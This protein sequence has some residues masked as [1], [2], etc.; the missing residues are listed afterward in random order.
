[1]TASIDRP[2]TSRGRKYY[3]SGRLLVG[4]LVLVV[5]AFLWPASGA[6]QESLSKEQIQRFQHRVS[7]G[8]RLYDLDKFRAA[9]EQFEAAR[10][11]FDHPRLTF[12]I[13]Q[14]YRAL[15]ECT[16]AR[17]AYERY[18]GI[19]EAKAEV[20]ERARG[21]LGEL[22]D[23][24]VETGRLEVTCSPQDAT[25]TLIELDGDSQRSGQCPV[26]TSVRV[27]R[28]LVVAE[29]DGY[30]TQ[31]REVTVELN[32]KHAVDL[33]LSRRD[34]TVFAGM[35]AHS[36]IAY[37]AIGL[38][39]ASLMG[40]FVSDYTAVGRLDELSQAQA[41]GDAGRVASLQREA[42]SA[43][44]RTA[45]LYSVGTALVVGG[46]TYKWVMSTGGDTQRAAS[47][48]APSVSVGLTPT[49]VSTRFQW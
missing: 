28:Y 1:M 2:A 5:A 11:L 47:A 35:D 7:E 10:E 27:G 34:D 32:S 18:I 41:Q 30:Q 19:P 8:R 4:A 44:T 45:V 42:D 6:A 43:S 12:N 39:A 9:L 16:S 38:G 17:A 13:A 49:G 48:A 31:E 26:D 14:S 40:G 21:I 3:P 24:C 37:S 36:L 22:D 15:N 23:T 20:R 33:A 29:A 25:L 46:V